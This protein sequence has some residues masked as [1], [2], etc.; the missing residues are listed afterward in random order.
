MFFKLV[1]HDVNS[2]LSSRLATVR[3]LGNNNKEVIYMKYTVLRP[4]SMFKRLYL[5]RLMYSY[6]YGSISS[7]TCTFLRLQSFGFS[8]VGPNKSTNCF[9]QQ[10]LIMYRHIINVS[11]TS[12][13]SF[14][15]VWGYSQDAKFHYLISGFVLNK[16]TPF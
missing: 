4:C 16:Q 5:P 6:V 12:A 11:W 3:A 7:M 10:T 8:S 15:T 14:V 1:L 9:M 13:K 2:E